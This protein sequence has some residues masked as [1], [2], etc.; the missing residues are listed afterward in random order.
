MAFRYVDGRGGNL[1]RPL[2]SYPYLTS[3]SAATQELEGQPT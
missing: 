1:V 2:S 3:E